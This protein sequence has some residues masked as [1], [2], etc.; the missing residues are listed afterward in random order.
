MLDRVGILILSFGTADDTKERAIM[1]ALPTL[2]IVVGTVENGAMTGTPIP[3]AFLSEGRGAGS[4]GWDKGWYGAPTLSAA[5]KALCK[6]ATHVAVI[7][8]DSKGASKVLVTLTGESHEQKGETG[9]AYVGSF[10][11][12]TTPYDVGI[13]VL[14]DGRVWCYGTRRVPVYPHTEGGSTRA[15][16]PAPTLTFKV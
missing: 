4:F 16:K 13:M 6:G 10:L 11:L 5:Q 3:L 12:G 7:S 9:T 15:S 14:T 1:A 8:T 2:T